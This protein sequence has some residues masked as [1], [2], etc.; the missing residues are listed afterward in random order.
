[1][2]PRLLDLFCGAG[3]ATKGYQQ[4]GFHVVGVDIREQPYYC[5]DEFVQAD[6]VTFLLDGFD[7]IHAS[8]PCQRFTQMSARWRG[9][10]GV[11]DQHPDCL[12]PTL[13]RLRARFWVPWVVENVVGARKLMRPTL[14]LHGGMFGLGVHRP[15]LFESNVLMLEPEAPRT[16]E[17][18]GVYGERP[19]GRRLWTRQ[20]G[21]MKGKRSELRAAK[22]L[23][24][25]REV[26]G[27]DWADWPG[28]KEA[29]P[30]AYSEFIGRQ[31]IDALRARDAA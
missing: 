15:R 25:A 16:R 29:I 31:L 10:G 9:N 20:N 2:R 23:A 12:T 3:G 13:E 8:P 19:N 30:P 27:M 28:T 14:M 22:S 6:A 26:M 4:A 5:G 11:T 21:D 18:V 7:A 1:V 17:P 24:Q